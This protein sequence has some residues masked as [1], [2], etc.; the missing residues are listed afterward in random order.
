MTRTDETGIVELGIVGSRPLRCTPEHPVLIY[1]PR[2]MRPD[3]II[4]GDGSSANLFWASAKDVQ[5]GDEIVQAGIKPDPGDDVL[6]VSAIAGLG[7]GYEIRAGD[8]VATTTD[9]K[10]NHAKGTNTS[11][12]VS[13]VHD[14][15]KLD[16][17]FGRWLGYYLAE[18]HVAKRTERAG[19]SGV[20]FTFNSLHTDYLDDA[21]AL[22]RS[23]FAITPR[24]YVREDGSTTVVANSIVLARFVASLVGTGSGRKILPKELLTAP[25]EF[26][27]GL[28]VGLCRGD[29]C[30]SGTGMILDLVNL[31]LIQQVRQIA[32]GLGVL[33]QTRV[34]TNVCGNPTGQVVVRGIPGANEAL[35]REVGKSIDKFEPTSGEAT[36]Y[37]WVD[38]QATFRVK[39]VSHEAGAHQVY[40]LE[41]EDTHTYSAAGSI[42]HNCFLLRVEDS[43][44]SIARGINSS[45]Q[46][47]KRGGGVALCLTNLRE[48]GAPIKRIE[49]QSSG[50]IPVMKLLEDSFSYANQLGARQ[51]A[52]AA[53][54]HAHHPDIMRFLDTKR[55]NADEKIRIKTLSLGVVIPDI[56]FE[57]AKR[58]EDMYLFSPYDVERVYGVAMTEI[59]V[60]EK[61]EE[62]V[63][64][65]RIAKTKI[66]ARRLFQTI[67]EIQFES[68][69]PY[70]LFEDTVNRAN[71][72]AGR[73]SMS[74]LCVTGETEILTA[75]GY[76][77]VRDL[78]ETQEDFDVV[79]DTRARDVDLNR[80]GVSVEK[81]TR[82]F[83]TAESADIF[84]VTTAEG[85]ELRA[86]EWHKMYV[87]RD[88]EVVKIPLNE[89]EPG[90][91]ILVQPAEGAFGT[92]H[93][94]DLA[95][96]AGAIAADGTLI[97]GDT[98]AGNRTATARIN[99]YG[100]KR[101][102][103]AAVEQAAAAA[104]AGRDD[105]VERQS[106]LTPKAVNSVIYKRETLHSAPLAK[107]LAERGMVQATKTVVPE[108]VL[109]GDRETQVAY[110][111]GFLQFEAT[112]T[113]SKK[114]N[115]LSVE[116]GSIDH[117]HLVA[118][119]RILLNL[120]V[121]T[122]IY[123]SRKVG[124]LAL[125]PDGRGGLK[126]YYQSQSWSL[127]ATSRRDV[128]AIVPLVEWLPR[129]SARYDE[130]TERSSGKAGYRTH[131]YRA[132][133]VSIEP[134]GVEDVYDVTVDNG[135][136]VIF[137]GISTG[138]C[139]E[140]TQVSTPSSFRDDLGYEHIGRDISC[141]LGS[142]NIAKAMDGGDLGQT[143]EVAVRAL[144]AVSDQTNISSVPSI[145]A[146]NNA[147]HAIG[148]GQMNLH[149]FLGRE[150]IHYGSPEAL[151]FTSVYFA[152]IAFHALRASNR[153]AIERGATFEGFADSAYAD[154]TY[155][156]KYVTRDWLPESARVRSLF[157]GT[158][159]ALPTQSDWRELRDSVMAHG[160]YNAYLQAVPPTGSI[161]Y[162]NDSTSS[163]HPIA[164]QIEI[165]KEGKL[166]RVY[167]PAPYLTNE[168]R[169]FFTDAYE[170]GP[171]KIID[172]YAA[173][174]E[175][176][177]QSLSLTLF[178]PDTVTTRDLNRAQIYAWRSGIKSLYYI[179]VRQ[180][181]L[182]GTEAEGCVSCAL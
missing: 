85:F 160:I 20:V 181:A 164:S 134:D 80:S 10:N 49:N 113:G 101:E 182:A 159:I 125:L 154:G 139:S 4:A 15:V 72:I 118:L 62:M 109:R 97:E 170:V 172:T 150:R 5:V 87:D 120:G 162:I 105:L 149:G 93:E 110:L 165:R 153:I 121:Y 178:F 163:I 124:G 64:D 84:K 76:R 16:Y 100:E 90:D 174:T 106:T 22:T 151:E 145:V 155:F 81:S 8:I 91:R 175:H 36:Q 180:Q 71:P 133:V 42:V 104:L 147:S 44:E 143:V 169:E 77:K 31:P 25:D 13:P 30:V 123:A 12:S 95:Y 45:L 65:A 26:R 111:N 23:V 136:S 61:Y 74:N 135:H 156:D 148:L 18:G 173:A 157:A 122:R 168:N 132:T 98:S 138:N 59:S 11:A 92:V 2:G 1:R 137:N 63:A 24:Q 166:G 114:Y 130:L 34:Y 52:G 103:T 73:I 75:G 51:G 177:D 9:A 99:M 108:F 66:S 161:S 176:V 47:S 126:E 55:E 112:I 129:H 48:Y 115:T 19:Y 70:I 54:L 167:Y 68:G 32:I 35:I 140:I 141:N 33:A 79:V 46:L 94:P 131:K 60:S 50:V 14:Q 17:D 146:G 179:R 37:R 117:A 43:M 152:A 107:L 21:D 56:T 29:G 119:Q 127:R 144:T 116:V 69:Y 7:D 88:G 3:V 78:Y 86:T 82:M 27:R 83:K 96:L 53:Y 6:S 58:N 57:L 158:G 38:G 28:L 102:F 41:V 89:V 40:N 171:E 128:D 142:L 67:A 39:S